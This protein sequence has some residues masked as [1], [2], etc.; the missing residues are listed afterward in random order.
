M[1]FSD[2][3]EWVRLTSGGARKLAAMLN[4]KAAE[5]DR[6]EKPRPAP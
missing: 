5:L 2:H 6:L 1:R 4:E 3:V